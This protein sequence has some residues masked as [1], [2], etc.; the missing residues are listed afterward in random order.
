M[1]LPI[2]LLPA[3]DVKGKVPFIDIVFFLFFPENV[4]GNVC[5][6][7]PLECQVFDYVLEI[8]VKIVK[9]IFVDIF[10]SLFLISA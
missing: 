2:N 1:L 8:I 5:H 3:L 10:L 6:I 7:V 9:L 4:L